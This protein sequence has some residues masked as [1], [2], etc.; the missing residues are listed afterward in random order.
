MQM[1]KLTNQSKSGKARKSKLEKIAQGVEMA[2]QTL[3]M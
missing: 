1:P 2:H 3:S